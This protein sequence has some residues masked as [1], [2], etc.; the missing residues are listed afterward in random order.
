[1]PLTTSLSLSRPNAS[2]D[3][4]AGEPEPVRAHAR[5]P[6]SGGEITAGVHST[7]W[8]FASSAALISRA[9]WNSSSSDHDG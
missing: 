2:V 3:P 6:S 5:S 7:V 1:M 4:L 8:I 9:R